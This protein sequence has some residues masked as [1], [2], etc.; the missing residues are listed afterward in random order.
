MVSEAGNTAK[1]A[2]LCV[3]E[4]V[5]V[6][7]SVFTCIVVHVCILVFVVCVIEYVP[8]NDHEGCLKSLPFCLSLMVFLLLCVESC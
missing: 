2:G 8:A 7:A 5:Q 3:A 4:Y 6:L 1:L